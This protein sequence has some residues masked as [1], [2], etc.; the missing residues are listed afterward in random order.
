MLYDAKRLP[1]M[2]PLA[3]IQARYPHDTVQLI[4]IDLKQA[5]LDV[6]EQTAP[7]HF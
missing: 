6:I 3:K 7:Y 2:T 4:T 1:T 5:G